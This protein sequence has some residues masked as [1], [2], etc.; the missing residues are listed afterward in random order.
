MNIRIIIV[1]CYIKNSR[2]ILDYITAARSTTSMQQKRR[3]ISVLILRKLR[4]YF[5]K[6]FL[7]IY[8]FHFFGEFSGAILLPV[9]RL[10]FCV[11]FNRQTGR[12]G[13]AHAHC[14][15]QLRPPR[16]PQHCSFRLL[17]LQKGLKIKLI[18]KPGFSSR[19]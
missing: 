3:F 7:I 6:L 8:F 4:N 5:F 13:F 2:K 15:R 18:K 1:N 11:C 17:K 19:F 9:L 16:P 10:S 14:L 12:S